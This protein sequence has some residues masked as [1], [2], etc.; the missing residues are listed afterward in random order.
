MAEDPHECCKKGS[1]HS[2]TPVGHET[3]MEGL[4]VYISEPATPTDKAI[5][6]LHDG[7]GWTLVNNRL[8]ADSYAKE[9][10]VRVF[11]PNLLVGEIVPAELLFDHEKIKQY[12]FSKFVKD[13]AREARWPTVLQFAK[14]LKEKH[15]VKSVACIGFCWGGWASLALAATDTVDAAAVAH[16]SMVRVPSD[17]ENIKK[18]TLFLCAEVDRAFPAEARQQA[19]AIMEKKKPLYSLF[20]L[21]PGTEHGFAVRGNLNN[22]PEADAAMDAK[23]EAVAFFKRVL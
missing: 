9:A 10:N 22:K 19:E 4:D 21:Y 2:G 20:K 3:K 13:N 15:G 12:D 11:L 7:F 5:L 14:S 23:N 1:V 17:I 8:L 18:P 6:F 16:P